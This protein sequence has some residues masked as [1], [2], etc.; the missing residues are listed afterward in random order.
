MPG[1]VLV[2]D[3]AGL[4]V[5]AGAVTVYPH[6]FAFTL[7]TLSDSRRIGPPPTPWALDVA[8]RERMTWLEVRYSDGRTRAADL[9]AN[10]PPRQPQGPHLRAMDAGGSDG[11]DISRWWVTPLPPP[12]PVD[13]A[14]HLNG[15][16]TPTGVGRLD[17]AALLSAATRAQVIWLE[18]REDR[19][20]DAHGDQE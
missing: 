6:G 8:E 18:P 4:A 19:P 14:I 16:K 3:A 20:G 17:G 13:L 10:T 12:G 2:V 5:W 1:D 7:R 9:N 15:D 11:C